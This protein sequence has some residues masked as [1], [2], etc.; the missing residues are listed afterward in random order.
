M[1]NANCL[2]IHDFLCR[3]ARNGINGKGRSTLLEML[4]GQ[5]KLHEGTTMTVNYVM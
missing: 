4:V 3:K 1:Q 2:S 5:E